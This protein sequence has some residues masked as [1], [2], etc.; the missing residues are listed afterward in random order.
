MGAMNVPEEPRRPEPR[1]QDPRQDLPHPEAALGGA[2]D[3]AKTTYVTGSGTEPE[4]RA[5]PRVPAA[6]VGGGMGIGGWVL[7]AAVV[8]IALFFGARLFG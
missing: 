2:D 3:V 1:R 7:I 5:V 6:R 4:R 8:G